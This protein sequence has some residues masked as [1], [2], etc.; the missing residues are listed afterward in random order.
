LDETKEAALRWETIDW[1]KVEA[2]V[3][4]I[5]TRIAWGCKR[6]PPGRKFRMGNGEPGRSH[7]NSPKH[8]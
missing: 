2:F 1:Q 7:K 4:K 8:A 6:S 3:N 5:Q